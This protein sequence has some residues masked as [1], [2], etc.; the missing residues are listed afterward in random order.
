MDFYKIEKDNYYYACNL[1]KKISSF[2]IKK[3]IEF[4]IN[5]YGLDVFRYLIFV[6]PKKNGIPVFN[7]LTSLCG[8]IMDWLIVLDSKKAHYEIL[9]FLMS[10]KI[11]LNTRITLFVRYRPHAFKNPHYNF[12]FKLLNTNIIKFYNLKITKFDILTRYYKIRK[13]R[14]YKYRNLSYFFT[15]ISYVL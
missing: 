10:K 14:L 8:I 11:T 13:I 1:K 4:L 5:K 3:N 7:D 2:I 9:T 15:A 6:N 12:I